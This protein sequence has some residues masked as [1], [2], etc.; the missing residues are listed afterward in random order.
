MTIVVSAAFFAGGVSDLLDRLSMAFEFD[1]A[2]DR[3]IDLSALRH[4]DTEPDPTSTPA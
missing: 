3:V 2:P 4:K 1:S